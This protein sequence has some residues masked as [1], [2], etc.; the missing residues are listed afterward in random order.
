MSKRKTMI[1]TSTFFK[2]FNIYEAKSFLN[3]KEVIII[4]L[5]SDKENPR[6]IEKGKYFSSKN[7]IA[8]DYEVIYGVNKVLTQAEFRE[9]HD[10]N[11]SHISRGYCEVFAESVQKWDAH[12]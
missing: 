10:M 4:N 11:L 5:S 7:D 8:F 2:T 3:P 1:I 12:F 9:W 6:V